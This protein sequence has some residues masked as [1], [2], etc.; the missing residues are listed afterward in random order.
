M[1]VGISLSLFGIFAITYVTLLSQINNF[2]SGI[3]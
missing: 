2:E 3:L 1:Y